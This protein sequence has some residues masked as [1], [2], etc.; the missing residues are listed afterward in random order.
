[1][2]EQDR[3]S[4]MVQ[5]RVGF[6]R[7]CELL[8]TEDAEKIIRAGEALGVLV[9]DVDTDDVLF[10]H[11][12]IQEYFA[13]R[14]L[15][16]KPSPDLV[17]TEWRADRVTPSIDEAIDGGADVLSTVDTLRPLPPTGWEETMVLAAAMSKDA[18]AFVRDVVGPNLALAGRAAAQ[19]DVRA[20]LSEGL[21]G[22][23]RWAL[24]HRSRNPA[25]D[26]RD[27]IGCGYALGDIGDPRFERRTGP[28][29]DYLVPPMIEIPGGVYPIG[30]DQPMEITYMSTKLT[31]T[32]VEHI[33]HHFVSIEP[34]RI[35]QFAVTNAEWERF[36]AA[37]GYDDERWWDTP[38]ALRW[39]RGELPDEGKKQNNR[40]W[41]RLIKEDPTLL[42]Q[43]KAER[44]GK[45]R[46]ERW[47]RWVALD[48]EE[49]ERE[50]DAFWAP[51]RCTEP[52][53]W[54]EELLNHPAQPVV[55]VCW[56]EARAYCNWLS[57]QTGL[58]IH[59][60][61][62]VE[63]EAAAAGESGSVYPW[64]LD[65]DRMKANTYELGLMRTTP[66]GVFPDGDT[67][68]GLCDM[69]GNV[70]EWTSS[71]GRVLDGDELIEEG[72]VYPYEPTDGRED[73]TA[74]SIISRIAKGGMTTYGRMAARNVFRGEASPATRAH[75]NGFRLAASRA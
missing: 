49:F 56:Y 3:L 51:N 61:T 1:M 29:G 6:G 24:V 57:A 15:S 60:P 35:G 48:D 36:M 32:A 55:G 8:D 33:P 7:A 27:R 58:T 45:A 50:L 72:F 59:L 2:Q 63:W 42:A 52:T 12:L 31:E 19:T 54:H 22:E 40:V 39:Q 25:A 53:Y 46:T 4:E 37:G 68:T 18:D 64:G 13:A 65:F 69:A 11:Q 21:L 44:G 20:R 16:A 28:L 26:L 62:E 71:L 41:R 9:E 47:H 75:N 70:V 5:V 23:L 74:A 43:M 10:F 17:R 34:F 38:D 73:P 67:P 30:D 66:V 14:A